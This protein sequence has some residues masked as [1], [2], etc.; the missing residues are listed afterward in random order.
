MKK[1]HL[2]RHLACAACCCLLP[3][4]TLFAQ[5]ETDNW[6]GYGRPE[7]LLSPEPLA[8]NRGPHRVGSRLTAPLTCVGSPRVPVVLVQF[9]DKKLQ[10][11]SANEAEIVDY[12]NTFCNGQGAGAGK[13]QYSISGYFKEQSQG[14]FTPRFSVL[15]PVTLPKDAA[16]YGQN[17]SSDTDI[18]FTEFCTETMKRVQDL[19]VDWMDF[20]NDG[21]GTVDMVFFIFAGMGENS[22][23]QPDDIWAKE[24]VRGMTIN[25]IT[26]ACY[27]C[28]AE[29]RP[30]SRDKETNQI[31]ATEPDGI[32]IACH[33]LSHALG[34]SDCYNTDRNGATVPG[35]DIFSLMDYG[36]YCGNGFNPVGYTA[37]E[38]DFMGWQPLVELSTPQHVTAQPITAGGKGYK[39][40]NPANTDE[41]YIVENRQSVSTDS[42]L[43]RI[44]HGLLVTHVDYSSGPWTSN[45]LNNNLNHQRMTFISAA[46][47][48]TTVGN[49]ANFKEW[50]TALAGHLWPGTANNRFL[51]DETTPAATVFTG[52][53]MG[54]PIRYITEHQD[55][56]VTFSFILDEGDG[57]SAPATAGQDTRAYDLTGRPVSPTHKGLY[58]RAGKKIIR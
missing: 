14:Q 58:I 22:S 55:G 6:M 43:G 20:D 19:D 34:L 31:T 4:S 23:K 21:N 27:A 35:M 41:Y 7:C 17:S 37:Y 44:T 40:T 57:I 53:F 13:N 12:Y 24:V 54:Q 32:G 3:H 29:L 5:D 42:V 52:G 11:P 8:P 56:S 51:T 45:T 48:P 25:G 30:L 15:G 9:A 1:T 18:H 38:R 28:C 39:I 2:L 47:D 46:N 33:E 50:T 49:A 26:Y 36:C 16:Y 10:T